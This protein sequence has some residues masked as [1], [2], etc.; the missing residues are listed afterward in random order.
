MQPTKH[1]KT[2]FNQ[3]VASIFKTSKTKKTKKNQVKL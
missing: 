2:D 3:V 1:N